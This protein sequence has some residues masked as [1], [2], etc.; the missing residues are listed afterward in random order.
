MN[1][2]AQTGALRDAVQN[3]AK[4]VLGNEPANAP[5]TGEEALSLDVDQ[6]GDKLQTWAAAYGL[7]IVGAILILVL[8]WI[9]AKIVRRVL[10]K[11][12]ERAKAEP[13][14]VDFTGRLV[15]VLLMAFVIVAAIS[16]L[17]VQTAS[18]VALIGAAGLAVGLAL[19]GSLG[20][21][22]AGVI[23]I[24]MRPITVGDFVEVHDESGTVKSISLLYTQLV[25]RD[26]KLVFVPNGELMSDN[27][28][29][30]SAL[31]KRRVDMV[32]GI[33]YDADIQQAREVIM[34]IL[35]NHD[36]VLEEP[37]P[38]VKVLEL[39]GSSVNLAVRP[40]VDESDYMSVRLDLYEKIKNALD[41]AGIGIPFPQRDVHLFEADAAEETAEEGDTQENDRG[42]A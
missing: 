6:L 19:Q 11:T 31:G 39:A 18:L 20:N 9:V 7:R 17:G 35:E 23:L 26:N 41:N 22:A 30:W 37:A 3:A 36:L 24:I 33:A 2:I 27:I 5:V 42:E 12:M 25:T 13:T 38:A 34:D 28:V 16:K 10:E 40:W 29:N 14:I 32:V 1:I 15:Y 4:E 21:F 8:G